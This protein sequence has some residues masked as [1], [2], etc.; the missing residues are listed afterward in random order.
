MNLGNNGSMIN[1]SFGPAEGSDPDFAD[2][3]MMLFREMFRHEP[4]LTD[5]EKVKQFQKTRASYLRASA[6][7]NFLSEAGAVAIPAVLTGSLTGAA[8]AA[9][10][11]SDNPYAIGGV[12]GGIST[13]V[14]GGVGAF[15]KTIGVIIDAELEI[16]QEILERLYN[17]CVRKQSVFIRVLW[18]PK[19]PVDLALMERYVREK[20]K[21][22][23]ELQERIE[24]G[25]WTL[26]SNPDKAKSKDIAI[27]EES[28]KYVVNFPKTS[29]KLEFNGTEFEKLFAGYPDELK[30]AFYKIAQMHVDSYSKRAGPNS[31]AKQ[32]VIFQGPS[33]VGKTRAAQNLAKVMGAQFSLVSLNGEDGGSLT[34]TKL[35]GDDKW[36]MEESKSAGVFPRAFSNPTDYADSES[37]QTY[38]NGVVLIDEPDKA[39]SLD[40]ILL[41]LLNDN[42]KN[43]NCGIM[44]GL[45]VSHALYVI[46][47]N[48]DKE[49]LT[50][51]STMGHGRSN[52]ETWKALFNRAGV[53]PFEDI[54][55][56]DKRRIVFSETIPEIIEGFSTQIQ[57]S[58]LQ[59]RALKEIAERKN[60]EIQLLI[61]KDSDPGMRDIQRKVRDFLGK[62]FR[63]AL[64]AFQREQEAALSTEEELAVHIGGDHAPLSPR[65][66]W[67]SSW[68]GF[69]D[70]CSPRKRLAPTKQV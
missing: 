65:V 4:S 66:S 15:I 25:L 26:F 51:A 39:E 62:E 23:V 42:T 67:K 10:G 17:A 45:D 19:K 46:C 54:T 22:P 14:T 36:P 3:K 58:D 30:G 18:Q 31:L 57:L 12:V 32:F 49:S 37:V 21:L 38:R 34:G 2:P 55:P 47:I 8:V 52:A 7:K 5:D 50:T 13:A 69:L 6:L 1:I 53:V 63:G 40:T 11:Q 29:K 59:K 68:F 64:A 16:N 43:M 44:K 9:L 27:W 70:C 60:S 48:G 24:K 61:D 41:T 56:H 35:W 33:G 28:L 20:S